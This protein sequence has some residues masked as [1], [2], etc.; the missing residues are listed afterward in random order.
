M[1][2]TRRDPKRKRMGGGVN[3]DGASSFLS[4][5]SCNC[6]KYQTFPVRLITPT[7]TVNT[8]AN[9]NSYPRSN[10]YFELNHKPNTNINPNPNPNLNP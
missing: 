3:I 1:L 7:Q 8:N 10:L 6:V 4:I 2:N 5:D 9:P